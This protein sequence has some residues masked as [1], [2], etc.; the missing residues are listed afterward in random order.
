VD[1]LLQ[2]AETVREKLTPLVDRN[3]PVAL[4]DFPRYANV[5]DSAI[6]AGEI[7][8]LESLGIRPVYTCDW[9]TYDRRELTDRIETGT[10]LLHGGG[11]FGD[12]YPQ[13]QS[14]RENV[15]GS[16]P[17]NPIVQLP[18]SIHFEDR[19]ALSRARSV[20]GGHDNFTLLVRDRPS[21]E[22]ARSQLLVQSDVCPDMAFCLGPQPRAMS[23]S[24]P[25]VW[26]MRTDTEEPA[27]AS[28]G[29]R[30]DWVDWK[31][32]PRKASYRIH[33]WAASISKRSALG[34]RAARHLLPATR[35]RLVEARVRRGCAMLSRGQAVVTNRLHGHILCLLLGLPHVLLDN[36]Y[37]KNRSFVDTWSSDQGLARWAD[38]LPQAAELAGELVARVDSAAA[39]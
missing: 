5:G 18:Q 27:S 10:I 25:I 3:L 6:W 20:F 9:R 8:F 39:D 4:V 29:R 13:H 14:F 26:L 16:F 24:V 38:S 35:A 30:C 34:R 1:W 31:E 22:I 32:E 28:A 36:T 33:F 23:P 2:M 12:L 15:M 37:G 17:D 11:N 19:S 21:L 7:R